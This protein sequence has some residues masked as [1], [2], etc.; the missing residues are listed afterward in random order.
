MYFL[1][2]FS[3]AVVST[4]GQN[5]PGQAINNVVAVVA[6]ITC[7]APDSNDLGLS[8][9]RVHGTSCKSSTLNCKSKVRRLSDSLNTSCKSFA[10]CSVNQTA[11]YLKIRMSIMSV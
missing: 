6:V 3:G 5:I 7:S 11:F 9:T 8:G 2:V 10:V 4:K 1:S